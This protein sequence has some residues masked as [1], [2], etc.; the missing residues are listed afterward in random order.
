MVAVPLAAMLALPRPGV[1]RWP[2]LAAAAI[3]LFGLLFP[4]NTPALATTLNEW[5]T[6]GG[7]G[8]CMAAMLPFFF[9]AGLR[10][11]AAPGTARA[12]G[13]PVRPRE[14][15][16]VTELLPQVTAAT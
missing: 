14:A 12:D 8:W 6:L 11:L 1:P 5:R 16:F 10:Y 9:I 13:A 15:P 2:A 4:P 3:L 7:T